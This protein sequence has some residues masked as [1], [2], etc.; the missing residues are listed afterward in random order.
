MREHARGEV[1]GQRVAFHVH[2]AEVGGSSLDVGSGGLDQAEF[3][4]G[5][6]WLPKRA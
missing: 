5:L 3:S 6:S 1:E 4:V 2:I